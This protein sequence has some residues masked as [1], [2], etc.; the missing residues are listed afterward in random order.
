MLQS[1][2]PDQRIF[3]LRVVVLVF[4][5]VLAAGL[6]I[7]PRSAS[8]AS[9]LN[10]PSES[11][12]DPP[13]AP[14]PQQRFNRQTNRRRGSIR[15]PGRAGVSYSKF[16]HDVPGHGGGA[17]DSCASCHRVASQAQPDVKDYP[18]HESCLNCH[19]QQFF[20]GARPMICTVCHTVVSP[21]SDARFAFPKTAA[22]SQSQFAD[23]FPHRKHLSSSTRT[24]FAKL[25]DATKKALSVQ[26]TCVHCHKTNNANLERVAASWPK[27]SFVPTPGT[28][29]TSPAGHASC[30]DCH[31]KAA[32]PNEKTAYAVYEPYINSCA[33]CHRN[34]LLKPRTTTAASDASKN[35]A[36]EK[37]GT[38]AAK[39]VPVSSHHNVDAPALPAAFASVS[40][41]WSARISPK[42]QHAIPSFDAKPKDDPHRS[43]GCT[44]CHKKVSQVDSL[45][46]FRLKENGVQLAACVDC[47]GD[48]G[49]KSKVAA[50]A[51]ELK[52]REQDPKFE[53]VYCHSTNLGTKIDGFDDHYKAIKRTK[54]QPAAAGSNT[55]GGEKK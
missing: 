54:P 21:R 43:T 23:I 50:I 42:F 41:A 34:A 11:N 18:N 49:G 29:M 55:S 47:H 6:F 25:P 12:I 17:K 15:M 19:R 36:A 9:E 52:A 27:K 30:V 7:F 48:K 20:A 37:N 14:S 33:E 8:N 22:S 44:D 53:C 13:P 45:E 38:A 32:A 35:A 10:N 51:R 16:T 26:D 46:T 2:L 5:A 1:R 4:F 40:E 24:A 3:K 31:W 39:F 28:F